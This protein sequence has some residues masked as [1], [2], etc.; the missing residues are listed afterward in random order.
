MFDKYY[1]KDKK[2]LKESVITVI[3]TIACIGLI[4]LTGVKISSQDREA[5]VI[6]LENKEEITYIEGDSYKNLLEGVRAED[7]KDGD[8]TDSIQVSRINVVDDEHAV[9][10]YVAKDCANNIGELKRKISYKVMPVTTEENAYQFLENSVD[11]ED[12]SENSPHITLTQY[13]VS[14]K[15][16]D[17]FNVLKYVAS[18]KDSDGSSLSRSIRVNGEY[19]VNTPG[20]YEI[21]VYAVNKN[22]KK[23]NVEKIVLTVEP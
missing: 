15:A 23:S 22:G 4:I 20:E 16:G 12:E 18:A 7:E 11:R 9:V 21:T 2:I 8:V 17:S 6:Y 13:E 3:L 10:V 19:D 1:E 14:I 5:P